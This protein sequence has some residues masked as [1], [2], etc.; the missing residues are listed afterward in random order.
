MVFTNQKQWFKWIP[1]VEWWYNTNYHNALKSTPFQA[2][3][4]FPPPQVPL[5]SLPYPSNTQA[6]ACIAQ[7]QT[8]LQHLKENLTQAQARMKFYADRARTDRQF[9]EGD[10]VYLKLQPYRVI[11]PQCIGAVAYRIDL[12]PGSQIHPVFHISQL[13]RRIGPTIIPQMQPPSYD[14]DGRVRI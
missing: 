11:L 2:L 7:R 3:Y 12:P 14:V 9:E 1:L 4:G 13:K 5:G 6:G 10:Y 8:I